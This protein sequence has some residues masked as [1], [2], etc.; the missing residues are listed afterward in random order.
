MRIIALKT[1]AGLWM[2][3]AILLLVVALTITGLR[4]GFMSISQFRGEV[5]TWLSDAL[6]SEMR[7]GRLQGGWHGVSGVL[8]V[9][10]VELLDADRERV[11]T[12]F[13][14]L[15]VTVDPMSMLLGGQRLVRL[16]VIGA[17]LG[18][19]RFE[20]RRI[21]VLGMGNVEPDDAD[22]S[23]APAFWLFSLSGLEILD[24]EIHWIDDR[25]RSGQ[26]PLV[27]TDVDLAV[28]NEGSVHRIHGS[29]QLPEEYGSRLVVTMEIEGDVTKAGGWRGDIY[30]RGSGLR[31]A[32]WLEGREFMG[33]GVRDGVIDME[34]WSEWRVSRLETVQGRLA[35]HGLRLSEEGGRQAVSPIS[36]IA[37]DFRWQR[38]Q[39]TWQLDVEDTRLRGVQG[40]WP[41]GGFSLRGE[42]A[43]AEKERVHLRL[44]VDHARLQDVLPVALLGSVLDRK[45]RLALALMRPEGSLDGLQLDLYPGEKGPDSFRLH[46]G[47]RDL[48]LRPWGN[49]PGLRG[50]DGSIDLSGAGGVLTLDASDVEAEF[51]DLFRAPLALSHI[52]GELTWYR[53]DDGWHLEL[54]SFRA[55]NADIRTHG[56]VRVDLPAD[57]KTFLD[58]MVAFEDGDAS[59]VPK[60]LPVGIMKD[61]LVSWLERAIVSGRVP[62]GAALFR[63]HVQDFPFDHGEGRFE[64]RFS[65]SDM[66]LD[67][68]EGWPRIEELE[69][70]VAFINR[71]M[72]IDA[73][74]GK[75]LGADIRRVRVGI[76]DL[77]HAS[78]AVEGDVE[79]PVQD[80]LRILRE[81]PLRKNVGGHV[82]GMDASGPGRVHV[83]FELPLHGRMIPTVHGHVDF[84]G[85]ELHLGAAGM[86]LGA[87]EGRL[88]F[89][90]EGIH[91]DGLK[92]RLQGHDLRISLKTERPA[93]SAPFTRVHAKG[94]MPLPVLLGKDLP[95]MEQYLSGAANLD[96]YL[97]IRADGG[98]PGDRSIDVRLESDLRGIEVKLPPPLGKT[99]QTK[100]PMQLRTSLDGGHH[101]AVKL[102][103]GDDMQALLERHPDADGQAQWRGVLHFGKGE[104]PPMPGHGLLITGHLDRLDMDRLM[105]DLP[106]ADA[107]SAPV[108]ADID[109]HIGQLR[110]LGRTFDD[111]DMTVNEQAGR[112]KVVVDGDGISGDAEL[113]VDRGSGAPL[114]IRLDRL[115]LAKADEEETEGEPEERQEPDPSMLP[116]MRIRCDRLVFDGLELGR[117]E[118]DTETHG[119][120][121]EIKRLHLDADV[122]RIDGD[123]RWVSVPGGGQT[124]LELDVEAGDLGQALS[125]LGFTGAVEQGATHMHW[126]INWPG[127]PG[128]FQLERLNGRIRLKVD[129][130]RLLEL[131]PGAGRMFGLLSLQALPRRLRLDFSDLFKK[132]FSFDGIEGGFTVVGG[133]AITNDLFMESPAARIDIAGR[134]GLASRDYDQTVTV[135]PH[136]QSSLP[137]AGALAGGPLVGAVLLVVDRLFKD[138]LDKITA[139]QYSVKGPWDDPLITKIGTREVPV[140][141][142]EPVPPSEPV[143]GFGELD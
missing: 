15:R 116:P 3:F 12:R 17:N 142:E 80:M 75:I 125:R 113:P 102:R 55:A 60:Y 141:E 76:D 24:S 58:L 47:I 119:N 97:K 127:G 129:K 93:S 135:T 2:A 6:G 98:R 35:V 46:A 89:T 16:T 121:L 45:L 52:D 120:V 20:D 42:M 64:I 44:G 1:L 95:G 124:R 23:A 51:P 138:K 69:A 22:A 5:E 83:A 50:V 99:A 19:R 57:G 117:L 33:F 18:L 112:W 109:L 82:E 14:H 94:R 40:E 111:L 34:V 9:Y 65:T 107:P 78:L 72:R 137:V 8:D 86:R 61:R 126:G 43:G 134:V 25:R 10:D 133:D 106:S 32:A 110:V 123:G 128:D 21:Q 103:Y 100:R 122:F 48:N 62:S 118:M 49:L 105:H 132:G 63:G 53:S 27:L 88:G 131:D 11:L 30:F 130:G 68:M 7:I 108:S 87:V 39:D 85:T 96:L 92:A 115:L 140:V 91:A 104:P 114:V 26:P 90:G 28:D 81:T 38:R 54:P 13:E 66:V 67:Y 77:T 70:D 59:T 71:S 31:P 36:D 41:L 29:V 139:T 84:L 37:G 101:G 143:P 73:V 79:G 4:L 56:R 136:V 74:G